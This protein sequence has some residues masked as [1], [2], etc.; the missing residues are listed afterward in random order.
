MVM[1]QKCNEVTGDGT[2]GVDVIIESGFLES[3]GQKEE[4]PDKGKT[5]SMKMKKNGEIV[6]TNV[7]LPFSQPPFPGKEI[8]K[9]EKWTGESK[10][11]IPTEPQPKTVTLTY[12]YIL[13][14]FTKVDGHDCVEIKVSCPECTIELG[15]DDQGKEITQV[16][17]ATGTTYFAYK[18]GML[19]KSEVETK[20]DITATNAAVKT[21]IKVKVDLVE[22]K[23]AAA[24][25]TEEGFRIA[26]A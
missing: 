23:K 17:S 7:D 15:K 6:S 18:E 4:L 16:L 5:I 13:W 2:L 25:A 1:M 11:Q 26:G 20:T 21:H 10:V 8:K 14:D 9:K 22:Q 3:E 24:G 12:N 19:I